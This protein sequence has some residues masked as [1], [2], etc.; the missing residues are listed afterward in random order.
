MY[1]LIFK[2]TTVQ[3]GRLGRIRHIICYHWTRFIFEKSKKI[4]HR[5]DIN[6]NCHKYSSLKLKHDFK[7]EYVCFVYRSRSDVIISNFK[8]CD[9]LYAS[10]LCH[11]FSQHFLKSSKTSTGVGAPQ[12]HKPRY[13]GYFHVPS[14]IDTMIIHEHSNLNRFCFRSWFPR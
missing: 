4:G 13:T 10:I 6:V 1:V 12:L 8:L 7:R 5:H 11:I 2:R 9:M 3:A 14:L